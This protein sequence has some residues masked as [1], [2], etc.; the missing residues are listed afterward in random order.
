MVLAV[1]SALATA[2]LVWLAVTSS[3][4]LPGWARAA[5]ASPLAM[6]Y[7]VIMIIGMAALGVILVVLVRARPHSRPAGFRGFFSDQGGT[8]AIEMAFVFPLGLMI[9]LVVI[10]AALV[11]NANMVVHYAAFAAARMAIVVV[12]LN[13]VPDN[14]P[15]FPEKRNWVRNPDEPSVAKSEKL[16]MIRQAAV[17]ALMPISAKSMGGQ[18]PAIAGVNPPS[19]Q[20]EST[21]VFQHFGV[22]QRPWFYISKS[23]PSYEGLFSRA[24]S[25]YNYASGTISTTPQPIA[26]QP[27]FEDQPTPAFGPMLVTQLELAKPEH[28]LKGNRDYDCPHATYPPV[29]GDTGYTYPPLCPTKN[30]N[31]VPEARMDYGFEHIDWRRRVWPDEE[32]HVR[33][34]YQFL[35]EVPYASRFMGDVAEVEGRAGKQYVTQIRVVVSFVNE[36]DQELKPVDYEWPPGT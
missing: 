29:W 3:G 24:Q 7:L 6:R 18:P 17:M 4:E 30:D 31:G 13:R 12:P 27:P 2:G 19:V 10:Q 34:T 22:D 35:L 20:T 8:A 33:V 32:L 26:S 11:F 14:D 25:Q 15:V 9:F 5:A 28:W 16:E 21:K 23:K 1:A 36:G